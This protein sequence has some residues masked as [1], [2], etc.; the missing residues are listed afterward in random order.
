MLV[1][2]DTSVLVAGFVAAHPKHHRAF[3]WLE[4]AQAKEFA[5]M[6]SAHSLT[7]CYAVLTRLPISPKISPA[8]AKLILE[9]NIE[10]SAKIISLTSSEYWSVTKDIAN[11]GL[12]GG[13]IYDAI[14][15]KAAKKANAEKILTFNLRDFQRLVPD[16]PGFI[17]TP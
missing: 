9:D 16:Q 14:T 8:L 11:I 7:E 2:F 13:I 15:V 12:S 17:V 10:K 1:L 6:V 5:W 4:R 3:S